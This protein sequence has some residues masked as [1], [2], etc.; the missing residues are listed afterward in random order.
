VLRIT[1]DLCPC[2]RIYLTGRL[3]NFSHIQRARCSS[4][5]LSRHVM[6]I[7]TS[8]IHLSS[9]VLF[10]NFSCKKCV[11]AAKIVK[12]TRAGNLAIEFIPNDYPLISPR[13]REYFDTRR[14][15]SLQ[16]AVLHEEIRTTEDTS[17]RVAERA[18]VRVCRTDDKGVFLR[19]EKI[20]C[21]R[22][23][24]CHERRPRRCCV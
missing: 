6:T 5:I 2:N 3:S 4:L 10:T 1:R 12:V 9:L 23:H 18:C 19:G 22:V 14:A 16:I 17:A 24:R 11:R 15:S 8:V 13:S 7:C 20:M 21:V